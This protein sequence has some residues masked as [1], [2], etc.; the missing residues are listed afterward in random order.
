MRLLI[1]FLWNYTLL[2][3]TFK[4]FFLKPHRK[5][6]FLDTYLNNIVGPFYS[7]FFLSISLIYVEVTGISTEL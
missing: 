6:Y 5:T 7:E 2:Y 1:K 4:S 3:Y